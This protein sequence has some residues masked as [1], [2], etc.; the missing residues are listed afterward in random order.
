MSRKSNM[1]RA[2]KK[3]HKKGHGESDGVQ[4][5]N[6]PK[7]EG[8]DWEKVHNEAVLV[9]MVYGTDEI[10]AA[11]VPNGNKWEYLYVDDNAKKV[12]FDS[13]FSGSYDD[14]LEAAVHA[15][16][17]FLCTIPLGAKD[18]SEPPRDIRPNGEAGKKFLDNIGTKLR[19]MYE[20]R[21]LFEDSDFVDLFYN[22]FAD[23]VER[24]AI[25]KLRHEEK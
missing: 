8:R 24:Q 11:L 14:P 25:D 1:K 16:T 20:A 9:S 19:A 23:E 13:A 12:W 7:Y 21:T 10:D 4:H 15:Y 5:S 18:D 3:W 22:L 6:A 17:D 2:A